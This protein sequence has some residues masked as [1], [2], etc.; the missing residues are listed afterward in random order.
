MGKTLTPVA[1]ELRKQ[2]IIQK[3]C[4]QIL[5]D[6][7][8]TEVR[9]VAYDTASLAVHAIHILLP[10]LGPERKALES[11]AQSELDKEMAKNIEASKWFDARFDTKWDL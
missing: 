3:D 6:S 4:L 7:Q 11:A 8:N 1:T 9:K 5:K 2:R 10:L